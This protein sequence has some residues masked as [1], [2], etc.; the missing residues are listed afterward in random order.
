MPHRSCLTNLL[1]YLETLTVLLYEGHKFDVFYIDLSKAF[2][3]V[4]HQ[5]LLSKLS[6]HGISE[7]IFNWV[8]SCLGDRMQCVVLNGS[9]SSWTNVV[10]GVPQD[11]V[12][13][14]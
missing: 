6:S 9:S 8:K 2:N 12:L 10:S 4:P 5:H 3:R 1:E 11:S 14:S 13:G 7:N